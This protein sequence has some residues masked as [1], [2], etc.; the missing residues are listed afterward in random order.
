MAGDLTDPM[1]PNALRE[2]RSK[3]EF[4]VEAMK[5]V[6][7]GGVEEKNI[8]DR[9][10]TL[11]ANDPVFDKKSRPGLDHKTLVKLSMKKAAHA[12]KLFQEQNMTEHEA[13]LVRYYVDEPGFADLHW[14]MFI[15]AIKGQGT[16]EQ[17]KKWL[18]LAQKMS[19]IGCYAQTELGHGSN[20]QGLETEAV[21]DP[22]ADEFVLHSP[23]LTSTKWWPGG[24][25]KAS[26]HAVV[27]ARL[28][29]DGK[30]YGVHAFIA[31]IRSLEDHHPLP[32]VTVGDIGV[33]FSNGGYNTMD[34]GLL[35]FDHVRIP[36]EN[37]LMRLATVT[38]EGKYVKSGYPKQLG[39]GAMVSVRAHIINDASDFLS[40]AVTIATRYSAVRRQ[41]GGGDGKPEIQVIDY[42]SQQSRLFPILASSYAFR[43]VGEW[44]TTLYDDVMARL[45]VNDFTTLPEVHACTAGLK[46]ICTSYTAKSIEECRILC[47][48]HGYL[49]SSGLPELYGAY[50]P[51]CTYEGDNTILL[52]Q[53]ARYLIK[54][55]SQVGGGKNPTGTAAY[56]GNIRRL[57]TENCRVKQGAEWLNYQTVLEAF[58]ARA[59][60]LS[61]AC[62][63]KLN[64]APDLEAAF[65]EYSTDMG[66]AAQAHCQVIIV[67]KFAEKM[68]SE[69]PGKGTK[70]IL[71]V[72]FF[73]YSLDLITRHAAEFL[74]TGYLT[75]EQLALAK[76]QLRA[77]FRKVRPNAVGL[78]DA[79]GHTD[80]YL[81][82]ILGR[83]DGDVYPNLYKAAWEEP[84]NDTV[85]A[86]GYEPYLRPILKHQLRQSKL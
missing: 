49:C 72:L 40:R 43:F 73:V 61:G 46:S 47:G 18:P 16:E 81:G 57:A 53:V 37:L 60:R 3:V 84:L 23:S 67:D 6:W 5:V 71:E 10:K 80:H 4:D 45:Q 13:T 26:T 82:S 25:G 27:Y 48:G 32:G 21:F 64:K 62:A 75:S 54:S 9:I 56:L 59:A 38:K 12:F 39:Y 19:I 24:L 15:P 33:K 34:N 70:D 86:E 1:G 36:R 74:S 68:K 20:V 50:V 17:Q 2:E 79:F 63:L 78:V 44:M 35:R 42:K 83:Y 69:F 77:C 29:T 8:Q 14:G 76:D 7:A 52:F 41:F 51:S 22:S 28:I 58:Q 31:Q 30:D 66:E 65:E 11:V 85:V 55:L